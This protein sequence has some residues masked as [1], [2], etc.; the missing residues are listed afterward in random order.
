[1]NLGTKMKP[2][3]SN[4]PRILVDPEDAWLLEY[5]WHVVRFSRNLSD[6]AV[7]TTRDGDRRPTILLHRAVL[8]AP[9]GMDVDH[10][11]GNG[12]DNRRSNLR[13]ALPGQNAAN[14]MLR[15]DN[16]SGYKG[17]KWHRRV[18][19]WQAAIGV[20][21]KVRSLGYFDTA[22]EAARAYD[23]AAVEFFGEFA[24]TNEM[25]GLYPWQKD[26]AAD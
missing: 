10:I 18:G 15:A 13:L 20:N 8:T 9:Q 26:E 14:T 2:G 24:K 25:L 22:E 11:N 12:L 4:D 5:K 6:Y 3:Q 1:M 19:C 21:G 7:R 16:T 17:A 23:K